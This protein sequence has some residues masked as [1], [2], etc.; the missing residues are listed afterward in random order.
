L[1]K[2]RSSGCA[3]RR[4]IFSISIVLTPVCPSKMS[5]ARSKN[6]FAPAR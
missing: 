2:R 4:S 3:S 5:Q 6:W 1:P